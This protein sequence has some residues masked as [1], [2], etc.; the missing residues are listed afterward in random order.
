MC[1]KA[2][3]TV[4]DALWAGLPVVKCMG[5][6][7]A[8]RMAGSLLNAVGLPELVTRSWDDYE[9]LAR[10]LARDTDMLSTVRARL[11][12]N[13]RTHPLFD[14]GRFC[15]HIEAAYAAMHERS[16]RGEPPESF[17]VDPIG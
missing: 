5:S 12:Q 4:S 15:R 8:S 2:G 13:R 6:S 3:A 1:V 14:T 7:I 16:A 10:T 9:T 11:A 17:A